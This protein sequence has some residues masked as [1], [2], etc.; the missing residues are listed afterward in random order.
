MALTPATAAKFRDN[1]KPFLVSSEIKQK[2]LRDKAVLTNKVSPPDD[3]RRITTYDN[4]ANH[5]NGLFIFKPPTRIVA[6]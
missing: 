6:S 3:A 2:N 4:S 1:S 5:A